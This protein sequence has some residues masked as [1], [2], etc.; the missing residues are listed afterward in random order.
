M[1]ESGKLYLP[2]GEINTK[3]LDKKIEISFKK[4]ELNN[5]LENNISTRIQKEVDTQ[6]INEFSNKKDYSKLFSYMKQ[7][8][9]ALEKDISLEQ[10]F[11]LSE[12]GSLFH[13]NGKI[14]LKVLNKKIGSLVK[15]K[16]EQS[17]I[18]DQRL[19]NTNSEINKTVKE[20]IDSNNE[21]VT[22][23]QENIKKNS[24]DEDNWFVKVINSIL[25]M[26]KH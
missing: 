9:V 14:N 8:G 21:I 3:E 7:E 11:K 1:K 5:Q 19:Q 26:L 24:K 2:S 12:T 22:Q 6:E 23:A 20:Y 10:L 13:E 4:R 17:R 16:Q 18:L 15:Y 25:E